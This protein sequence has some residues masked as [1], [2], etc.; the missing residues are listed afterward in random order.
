VVLAELVPALGRR[1]ER[2]LVRTG[3]RALFL[4]TDVADHGSVRRTAQ[5]VLRRFGRVDCLVNNAAVLKV[6]PLTA[7]SVR[8]LDRM[9][10]VNL[11]GPLLLTRAL[12]PTMRRQ[13]S[14]SIIN[15]ASELGKVGAAEYVTYCASKFGIVGFTE[16]LAE[17]LDGTGLRVWAVCPG[18]VDTPMARRR[19][20]VP[21]RERLI[22]PETVARVIVNLATGRTRKASGTAVDVL[23]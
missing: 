8:D 6:G 14:G 16:A 18:L 2:A 3:G 5:Q 13:R 4:R 19:V 22:R 12:L 10:A 7:S 21:S 1:T 17:E 15:V 9:L 20:G 11:R 23:R